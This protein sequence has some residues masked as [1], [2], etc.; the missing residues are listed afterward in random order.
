MKVTA[1]EALRALRAKYTQATAGVDPKITS[2]LLG[3][4]LYGHP[5]LLLS[6]LTSPQPRGV[7]RACT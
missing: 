6:R 5:N 3:Y 1:G 4:Q 2:T 7:S